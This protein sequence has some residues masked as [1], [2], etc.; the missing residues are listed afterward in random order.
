MSKIFTAAEGSYL[1]IST[2]DLLNSVRDS[3]TEIG[4]DAIVRPLTDPRYA[5]QSVEFRLPELKIQGPNGDDME[6]LLRVSNSSIPGTALSVKIGLYRMICQNGLFG[7]SYE[8]IQRIVHRTGPMAYRKLDEL[9]AAIRATMAY[10]NHLQA[11]C[12]D[13]AATKIVDPISVIASLPVPNRVKESAI[14]LVALGRYRAEDAPY[15]AWG[16]YNLVN[17]ID[18][19]QSRSTMASA[20]RDTRLVDDIICLASDQEEVA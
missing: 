16:L 15:T 20:D 7:F 4:L 1:Y 2:D 6:I 19:V 17:E 13:L 14:R 9:P 18:R 11:V 5:R 12:D 10:V 3:L 8:S